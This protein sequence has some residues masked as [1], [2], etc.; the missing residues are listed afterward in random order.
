MIPVPDHGIYVPIG[1]AL[2]ISEVNRYIVWLG[3]EANAK[4]N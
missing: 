1:L 3:I 4:T 2:I